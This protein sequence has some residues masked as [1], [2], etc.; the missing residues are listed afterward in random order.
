[1][2]AWKGKLTVSIIQRSDFLIACPDSPITS[3]ISFRISGR[4]SI[5]SL[6]FYDHKIHTVIHISK[7]ILSQIKLLFYT[8]KPNTYLSDNSSTIYIVMP[9]ISRI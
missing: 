4:D 7:Y 3:H 5:W 1:M 6:K 8:Q 9:M 2:H